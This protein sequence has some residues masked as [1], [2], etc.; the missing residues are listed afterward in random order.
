MTTGV[1]TIQLIGGKT[2]TYKLDLSERIVEAVT[3]V[4]D[5][6]E[7]IDVLAF[8]AAM[9]ECLMR[10]S[11]VSKANRDKAMNALREVMDEASLQRD[12]VRFF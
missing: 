1:Q 12:G 5:K 3:E 9:L 7:Q 6:P 2:I 4:P 11:S 8:G 10:S